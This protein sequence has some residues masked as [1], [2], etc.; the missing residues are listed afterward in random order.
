MTVLI[1]I[2]VAGKQWYECSRVGAA[3]A[4]DGVPARSGLVAGD[5]APVEGH[6]VVAGGDVVECL[7]VFRAV[8]D[9]VDGGIDE[10]EGVAGFLV[11]QGDQGGPERRGGAGAAGADEL[12]GRRL[13]R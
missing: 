10:A 3:P 7:V 5:R 4:G 8:G 11:C 12:I 6:G 1:T 13:A 9:A 2:C